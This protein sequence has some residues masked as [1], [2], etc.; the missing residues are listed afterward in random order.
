MVPEQAGTYGLFERRLN[1]SNAG[2]SPGGI[3]VQLAVS[4]GGLTAVNDSATTA[5]ETP[6]P[7]AVLGNDCPTP[8]C[9][10]LLVNSITQPAHGSSTINADN[11]VTY[12]PAVNFFGGDFFTYRATDGTNVSNWATVAVT[13]TNV[14]DPPVAAADSATTNAGVPVT[15]A[16]LANDT[17][18]DGDGLTVTNLTGAGATLN[19]NMVTFTAAAAGTYEFT[20]TA[21]DGAATS[22]PA[23][24]TVTVNAV[25]NQ[26]PVAVADFAT[27]K[28]RTPV[29]INLVANDT[30]PDGNLDPSSIGIVTQPTRGGTITY[31]TVGGVRN[32]SVVY[33]PNG[34]FRGTD[35]F[36]YNVKD[37]AGLTSNTAEVRVNVV[38]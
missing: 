3:L 13:V 30:D 19:D 28:Q 7:I 14:N 31:I 27:T 20:Y 1:V 32:G 17:D 38:K 22:A 21:F 18:V 34:N 10:G 15:I 33:T 5:E 35:V 11:T 26:A 8:P 9:T 24:V 4:A 29:T 6:V 23:T 37:L 36:T 12:T 16:V 2:A 25:A